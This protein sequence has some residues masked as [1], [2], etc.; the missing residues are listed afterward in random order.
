MES[1]FGWIPENAIFNT[2]YLTTKRK[3]GEGRWATYEAIVKKLEFMWNCAL[4]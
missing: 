4:S 1:Q 2:K 3:Q